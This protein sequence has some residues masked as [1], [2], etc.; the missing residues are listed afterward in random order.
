[1][2]SV[3]AKGQLS[4]KKAG[5]AVITVTAANGVKATCRITVKKAPK[6]I[7]LSGARKTLKVGKSFRLK[8]KYSQ[9]SA[10]GVTFRSSKKSVATVSADG[11]VTAKKRGKVTITAKSYNGKR[12]K[13]VIRVTK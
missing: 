9:G 12:A 3:N 4:A 7:K 6:S 5:K 11:K 10:G 2:V 1:M 8:V 13:V